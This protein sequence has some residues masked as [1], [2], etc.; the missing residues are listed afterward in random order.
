MKQH[1]KTKVLDDRALS[2]SAAP[3]NGKF[4]IYMPSLHVNEAIK[5]RV[6]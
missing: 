2:L 1:L 4:Y 3:T 6:F 5:K